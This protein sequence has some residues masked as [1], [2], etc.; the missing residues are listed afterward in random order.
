MWLLLIAAA[1]AVVVG[2]IGIDRYVLHKRAEL[3][4]APATAANADKSIAVLPFADLSEKHDQ[5]YFADGVA[6]EILDLLAKIPGLKV[7]GR[8]SSFQF[9]GNNSDLRK[10]GAT[11]GA[12][13]ILEGSVRRSGTTVKVTV[14]LIDARDGTHRW[15]ET[16]ERE[17]ADAL[18]L[19]KQIATAVARELQVSVLDYFGPGSETKSLEAYDLYLRGLRDVDL[20]DRDAELR[21][22]A[23]MS[24][25]VELDPNYVNALV[26][27][28][29]AYDT[30]AADSVSPPVESYRLARVAIDKALTLDPK[31][32]DAYA[33]RAFI[34]MNTW[35]WSGAEQDIRRSTSLRKTSGAAQAEA[36]LAW[37][38]GDLVTAEG[39]LRN[40][41]AIDPLD[42][43]SLATLA[44]AVYPAMGRFTDADHLSTKIRD[45]DPNTRFINANASLSALLQGNYQ[46]ALRLAEMEPDAGAKETSLAIVYSAMRKPDLSRQAIDRLLRV[47]GITDYWVAEAYAY[48]G[49]KDLAFRY[50]ERAY[51]H[52][53]PGLLWLKSDPLLANLRGEP[54]YKALLHKM[55]L[56]E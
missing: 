18:L 52:Y 25:A 7:I 42:T 12:T 54:R 14:Q 19:Q 50:L 34:R 17:I 24:K 10:I 46:L 41:L 47:P 20:G 22:I 39:L 35:D 16:Y 8:T 23:E 1:V 4:A 40:I 44:Y 28:A 53:D 37:I 30:A 3:S 51:A 15:S 27:L 32:A 45:I 43:D 48:V 31:N 56:P 9:K 49:E 33:M 5:E 29:D 11:L 6:E 21:A 55:N 13:Y 38:R 26:G 2:Y 36:K